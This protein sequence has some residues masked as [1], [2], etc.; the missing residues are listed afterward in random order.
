[1]HTD[2]LLRPSF[3]LLTRTRWDQ[4]ARK[5]TCM[6]FWQEQAL[7]IKKQLMHRDAP[8][9][10]IVP[11]TIPFSIPKVIWT[12]VSA[13]K[14]ATAHIDATNL[15]SCQKGIVYYQTA[16]AMP[17]SFYLVSCWMEAY[18]H[19]Q[20]SIFW[21]E[22]I[23][24]KLVLPVSLFPETKCEMICNRLHQESLAKVIFGWDST[25]TGQICNSL[26]VSGVLSEFHNFHWKW[27]KCTTAG[28]Q[29]WQTQWPV[30]FSISVWNSTWIKAKCT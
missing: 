12:N 3:P 25:Q 7:W 5:R 30:I 13:S 9:C 24:L 29:D 20:I 2:A 16:S 1:M 11:S 19:S 6:I 27:H 17:P 21:A 18:Q 14:L 8:W 26:D 15:T 28:I 23:T 4:L 22:S 10:S